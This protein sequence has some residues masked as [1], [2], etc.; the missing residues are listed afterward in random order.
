MIDPKK[1]VCEFSS[2][3]ALRER[4]CPRKCDAWVRIKKK[5]ILNRRK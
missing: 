2:L 3:E 1:A 5:T 4:E